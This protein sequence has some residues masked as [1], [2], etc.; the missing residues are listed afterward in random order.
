MA[1]SCLPY[2]RI[3]REAETHKP[4][5]A[6]SVELEPTIPDPSVQ[7]QLFP[8]QVA[9]YLRLKLDIRGESLCIGTN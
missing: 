3:R 4:I 6:P 7:A 2:S 5:W 8:S 1:E 9:D